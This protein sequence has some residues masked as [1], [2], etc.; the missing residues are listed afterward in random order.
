MDLVILATPVAS[1]YSRI[2]VESVNMVILLNFKI[3]LNLVILI[4]LVNL[5][6]WPIL[7]IPKKIPN[8]VILLIILVH[9]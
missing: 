6:N 7:P 1:C 5:V 9:W 3:L 8:L 2:S 4:N